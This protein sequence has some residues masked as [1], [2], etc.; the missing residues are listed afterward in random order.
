MSE[1]ENEHSN[2]MGL[3]G[4]LSGFGFGMMLMKMAG[5][6]AISWR[7]IWHYWF[8]LAGFECALF[9]IN[10]IIAGILVALKDNKKD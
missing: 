10:C 3:F 9:L 4:L 6:L 5:I 8:L 2:G 7:P 1:N